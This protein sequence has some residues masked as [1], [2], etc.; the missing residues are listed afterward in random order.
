MGLRANIVEESKLAEKIAKDFTGK[1]KKHLGLLVSRHQL[2]R[3]PKRYEGKGMSSRTDAARYASE[4]LIYFMGQ[5]WSSVD[6]IT[7]NDV[8]KHLPDS[9]CAQDTTRLAK[10]E[11]STNSTGRAQVDSK[12]KHSTP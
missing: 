1:P 8:E 6:R 4:A 2:A 3:L 7:P 11:S 10:A 12:S 9:S 5:N